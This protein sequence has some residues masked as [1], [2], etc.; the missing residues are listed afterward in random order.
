MLKVLIRLQ[1]L[2]EMLI[3]VVGDDRKACVDSRRIT[4]GAVMLMIC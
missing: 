4:G 2:F 3:F 1:S